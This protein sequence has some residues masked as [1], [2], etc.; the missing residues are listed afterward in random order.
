LAFGPISKKALAVT[1]EH[2]HSRQRFFITGGALLHVGSQ[3]NEKGVTMAARKTTGKT[4]A[5][6]GSK[7]KSASGSSSTKRSAKKGSAKKS[8][9][10]GSGPGILSQ[11]KKALK[12][13]FVGAASGAAEGA[14]AGAADAGTKVT[15][16]SKKAGQSSKKD[17]KKT[18]K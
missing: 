11:A 7:K 6:K 5:K 1:S 15:G 18:A 9:K 10:K 8:G 14:V 13:V 4:S 16:L 2:V 17:Q 12:A 3:S